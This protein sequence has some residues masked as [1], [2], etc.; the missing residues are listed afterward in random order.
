MLNMVSKISY[1]VFGGIKDGEHVCVKT[2][3]HASHIKK[4]CPSTHPLIVL[5]KFNIII[6][7]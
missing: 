5:T 2:L 6:H 7:Y 3:Q 4:C 1:W